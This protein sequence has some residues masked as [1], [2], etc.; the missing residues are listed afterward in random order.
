M[1]KFEELFQ[2][3]QVP[4]KCDRQTDRSESKP[5]TSMLTTLWNSLENSLAL[6]QALGLLRANKCC[7]HVPDILVGLVSRVPV[8]STGFFQ[9][10]R[11]NGK[12]QKHIDRKSSSA[13]WTLIS[14]FKR[15]DYE[16]LVL[17]MKADGTAFPELTM[18]GNPCGC[19]GNF[20]LDLRGNCTILEQGCAQLLAV[21][22][23]VCHGVGCAVHHDLRLPMLTS[24][25][26]TPALSW[27]LLL[28]AGDTHEVNV[29][30]E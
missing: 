22:G 24:I 26:F 29:L 21:H 7:S 5:N 18:S 27:S 6:K 15:P 14:K 17:S 12:L 20:Y 19:H 9:T 16:G 11:A 25:P 4:E 3:S 10:P 28:T 8:L 23:D 30:I 2:L 1:K 13:Q